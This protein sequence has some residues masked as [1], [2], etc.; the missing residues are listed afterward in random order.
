MVYAVDGAVHEVARNAVRS[1][2]GV[3]LCSEGHEEGRLTHLVL[4]QSRRTLKV[5]PERHLTIWKV[6]RS[7]AQAIK[8]I[9]VSTLFVLM[10]ST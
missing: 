7:H 8:H 10:T 5:C 4:G 6:L 2:R 9:E 3:R 1:L